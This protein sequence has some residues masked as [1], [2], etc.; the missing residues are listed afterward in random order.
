MEVLPS[1]YDSKLKITKV[2]MHGDDRAEV[3]LVEKE[4]GSSGKAIIMTAKQ[5]GEWRVSK[6]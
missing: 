2:V 4:K 6:E 3:T 1:M 5:N